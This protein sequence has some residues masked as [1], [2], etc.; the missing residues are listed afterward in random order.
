MITNMNFGDALAALKRGELISRAGWN[1]KKMYLY[2]QS[3]AI[4][5]T[6]QT[7]QPCIIMYTAEQKHQPGWLASQADMLAEDWCIFEPAAQ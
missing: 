6:N 3:Y 7:L 2:L 4:G 5:N 1:G